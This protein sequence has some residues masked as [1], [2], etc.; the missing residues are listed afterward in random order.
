MPTCTRSYP[1]TSAVVRNP[2]AL[3]CPARPDP[4]VKHCAHSRRDGSEPVGRR[5]AAFSES[6]SSSLQNAPTPRLLIRI[7]PRLAMVLAVG[8]LAYFFPIA[9]AVALALSIPS[10]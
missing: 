8:D 2:T 10:I 9:I 7:S 5:P 4:A 6:R 3:L 1:A